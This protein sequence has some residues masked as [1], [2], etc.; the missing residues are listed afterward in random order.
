MQGFGFPPSPRFPPFRTC[1]ALPLPTG[2]F[3][4]PLLARYRLVR[5]VKKRF[6]NREFQ[7]PE[8]QFARTTDMDKTR[9]TL[10]INRFGGSTPSDQ[11]QFVFDST[12]LAFDICHIK[13]T[14]TQNGKPLIGKCLFS[15]RNLK[16]QTPQSSQLKGCSVS[17]RRNC[18]IVCVPVGFVIVNRSV[19]IFKLSWTMGL[20]T[21]SIDGTCQSAS[22]GGDCEVQSIGGHEVWL[23]GFEFA[24]T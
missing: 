20:S 1:Q 24:C 15:P 14:I 13:H 3:C 7:S 22:A 5:N 10:D 19:G 8:S 6:Q 4:I 17:L 18:H 21:T 23:S 16:K 2:G 12:L 11:L 9:Q